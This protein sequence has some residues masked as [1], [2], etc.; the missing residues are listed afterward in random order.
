MI[1]LR[2]RDFVK[3]IDLLQEGVKN[4]PWID[5]RQVYKNAL[6]IAYLN[7]GQPT[8]AVKYSAGSQ[9]PLAQLLHIHAFGMAGDTEAARKVFLHMKYCP[10]SLVPLRNELHNCYVKRERSRMSETWLFDQEC[11]GALL[12][13][14]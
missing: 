14:A 4:C 2:R 7:Q 9:Q 11:N 13:A 8:E 6:S 10:S 12:Q 1:C 3:A 5:Q